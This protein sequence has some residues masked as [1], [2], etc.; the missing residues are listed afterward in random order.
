[1]SRQYVPEIPTL[2][3]NSVDFQLAGVNLGKYFKEKY[4]DELPPIPLFGLGGSGYAEAE[5]LRHG[6][7][8]HLRF[9]FPFLIKQDDR[10]RSNSS[11]DDKKKANKAITPSPVL[12]VYENTVRGGD[13]LFGGLIALRDVELGERDV[14][15]VVGK[16]FFERRDPG[17]PQSGVRGRVANYALRTSTG[18][19]FYGP[20]KAMEKVSAWEDMKRDDAE[21]LLSRPVQGTIDALKK[22]K[23]WERL[24]NVDIP[25]GEEENV[26]ESNGEEQTCQP[27][28]ARVPYYPGGRLAVSLTA[29]ILRKVIP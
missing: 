22:H 29:F 13:A 24:S 1:M 10:V 2:D 15:V 26:E 7:E 20:Q 17:Y 12:V 28:G 5:E 16:D 23:I 19:E 27:E 8:K 18:R 4:G 3:L 21:I 11:V 25:Y 9:T 6:A 14:V